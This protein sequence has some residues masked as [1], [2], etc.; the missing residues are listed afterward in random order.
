MAMTVYVDSPI[1]KKSPTGRKTYA[2]M[3]ADTIEELRAFAT[4]IGVKPHF[5]HSHDRLSHYDINSE[6]HV[7][8][9]AQGAVLV[10]SR[11]L[12]SKAYLMNGFGTQPNKVALPQE[13]GV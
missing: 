2:H 8:A 9:M 1:Y 3:V 12:I 11:E 5:W 13:E 7:I 6:Q 10:S 4:A